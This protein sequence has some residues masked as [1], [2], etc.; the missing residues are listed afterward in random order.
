MGERVIQCLAAYDQVSARRKS[1]LWMM[2]DM[3]AMMV[4][5]SRSAAFYHCWYGE[6]VWWVHWLDS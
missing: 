3:L 1:W 6:E 4:W 5:M 2:A